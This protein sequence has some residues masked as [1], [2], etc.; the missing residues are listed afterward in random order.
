M[1]KILLC[2]F[3][4]FMMSAGAWADGQRRLSVVIF[5]TI[6][7]TELEV[8]ESKYYPYNVLEQKMSEYLEQLFKDSPLIEARVLDEAAMNRWL[9]GSRRGDDMAVQL[10]LYQATMKERHVVGTAQTGRALIRLRVFDRARVQE[11][12]VRN[13]KG[14]DKRFTLD[15][16]ED[17]YWFDSAI[18]GLGIPFEYG[19]DLF[20]LTGQSYKG[21]K[22]SRPTWDQFK[23]S[24]HWQSIKK[25]IYEAY[26]QSMSQVR[27]AIR[28]NEPNAQL[29]GNDNFSSSYLTVGRI[30]A[31]T[32]TSTRKRRDYIISL[33]SFAN[34]S[35]DS[36]RVGEVLE[37]VRADTYV[38]VVPED[39]V[40]V[41][42]KVIGRVKVIK[43]YEDNAVVRVI[44]DNRKEPITLK[45]IVVKKT[46]ITGR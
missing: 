44:K 45:D 33:G 8:W 3:I 29:T 20:G 11:I 2:L 38:T 42:P 16:D 37:V 43:V 27:N 1:K 4:F 10:E 5:P 21:Q 17:I 35:L 15:S 7:S 6:N 36:V 9:S 25:A 30:L 18:S 19:L 31:P 39:P 12:G 24:S 41:L 46:A 22:M 26:R 14:T 40:V 28:N 32:A 23:G 34:G 13:V